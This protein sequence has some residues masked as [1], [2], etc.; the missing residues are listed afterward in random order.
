ML[1]YGANPHLQDAQGFNCLHLATHSHKAMLV[2]YLLMAEDMQADAGDAQGFTS[3]MWAAKQGDSL[4]VE[5]LLKY[6]ARAD[7]RNK[8]GSTALHWAVCGGNRE[9]MTKILKAGTDI[10][11][12]DKFGK[13]PLDLVKECRCTSIW[14]KS[15]SD[16]GL[17][18]DG[19]TRRTLFDKKT[20]NTIIYFIPYVAL[21]LSLNLVALFPWYL[22]LP[23]AVT[24][25]LIGHVGAIKFLLRTKKP[26]DMLQ[27]PYY[28][29]VFQSTAFL[30]GFT[31]LRHLV[32]NTSHLLWMNIAF[33]VGYVSALYFFYGAVMADPGWVPPNRAL[34]AQRE[35][36]LQMADR[37]LLDAKHFC[38]ACLIQRPLRSKHCRFCNRCVAKFDHH[39]PWIYNCIGAKNHRAFIVFLALFLS[40]VPVY[41]YLSFEYLSINAPTYVPIESD[42]CLLTESLCSYFQYDGFTTA[43]AF[44]SL[45][46]MTW[47]SL[48]FFVQLYQ[49]T[50]GRTTNE[51]LSFPGYSS[52]SSSMKIRQR[53]LRSLSEIDS[54]VAGAGHPLQEENIHL[55]EA[56]GGA[57]DDSLFVGNDESRAVGIGEHSNHNHG[58]GHRRGGG[59]WNLLVGTARSR[60]QHR[61]GSDHDEGRNPFDFGLLQNCIGFFSEDKRGPLRRLNW[62]AFYEAENTR[63]PH[64]NLPSS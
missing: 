54:E 29:A 42:P 36:V 22:A 57:D 49:I 53:I 14:E 10:R 41:V 30:V 28:T 40:T 45:I 39:C 27:T 64:A 23:L 25:F 9:C 16:A 8:D 37:H 5:V 2:L 51:A 4:T 46:Q 18:S 32:Y 19:V 3:L 34:D 20:T 35:A 15:L 44:W 11:A 12:Q 63:T 47:P 31:W 38:I 1:K 7:T 62:Y 55:L 33:L 50:Q 17:A 26:N 48:L 43:L 6:G 13:T 24:Q 52:G 21:I 59:M 56:T 60:H 58:H 61:G